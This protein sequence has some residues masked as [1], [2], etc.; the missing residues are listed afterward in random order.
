MRWGTSRKPKNT[1][2]SAKDSGGPMQDITQILAQLETGDPAAAEQLLPLV[3]NELR[4]LA[5]AKLAQEQPGQ[6]LQAT[7]LVHEAY[8]RIVGNGERRADWNGR[9]HFF[10]A[11]AEAMRRILV[12]RARKKKSEKHGGGYARI[13]LDFALP[14]ELPASCDLLELDDV[15]EQLSHVDAKAAELVKLRF[16]AGLTG[17]Q[18]ASVLGVS[19]RS[20]D[21][22]WAYARAWLFEKLQD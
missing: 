21:F 22:L 6:T 1:A 14:V 10:A 9:G 20:V 13:D 3:Y 8:L 16:F 2:N 17:E 5:A 7:A 15:L 4:K 19:P 12:E 11:A 18:A